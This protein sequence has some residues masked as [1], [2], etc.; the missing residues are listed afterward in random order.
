MIIFKSLSNFIE[1]NVLQKV[2]NII[3]AKYL[4]T[5]I[6]K[7]MAKYHKVVIRFLCV[8]FVYLN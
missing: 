2:T 4:D 3:F 5:Y 6:S 1:P 8:Y 7:M